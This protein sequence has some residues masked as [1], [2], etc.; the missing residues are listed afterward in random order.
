MAVDDMPGLFINVK[1][2]LRVFACF[3]SMKESMETMFSIVFVMPV[4]QV[5]IMQHGTCQQCVLITVK[6]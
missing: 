6:R 1:I 4:V 3:L 5:E 2:L